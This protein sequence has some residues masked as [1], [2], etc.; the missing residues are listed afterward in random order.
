[1]LKNG[2]PASRTR[3]FEQV[4]S[5]EYNEDPRVKTREQ[6]T[7]ATNMLAIANRN[8]VLNFCS[9]E[10]ISSTTNEYINPIEKIFH[11]L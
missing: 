8:E 4:R 6:T 10:F 1:M 2:C 7:I 9:T 5:N 3:R 11:L